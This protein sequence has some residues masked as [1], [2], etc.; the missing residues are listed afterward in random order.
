MNK[1]K[2]NGHGHLLPEPK[3]IP[4]FMREKKLFWIDDDKGFMR[5]GT[6]ARPITDPSFFLEEKL[7]WMERNKIEHEVVLNLSQLYCNGWS[8][9]DAADGI[10]FQNDFNAQVQAEN[11]NKFTCGFVVQPRYTDQ[12]LKEIERCVTQLDMKLLC[13]P[14]H[15]LNAAGQWCSSAHED[16][17]PIYELANKY[18]LA[19]EIHPYDGPK[20]INLEDRFW[21]FHLVWMCAQ[22]ADTYHLY[23][24]LGIAQKYP[25]IRTCF[26]HAN[27]YGQANYGRR[28]QGYDGRPDLFKGALDPRASLGHPNIFFDTLAHDPYT[29]ELVKKR[30][31]VSQLLA[32]LDDP[33][34]LGEMETVEGCYPGKVIDEA[35]EMGI[36]TAIEKEQIWHDNVLTWL[37]IK[38][39]N[40]GL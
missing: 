7:A 19:I 27:Q 29:L 36:F 25:N 16:V 13:L 4:A 8:E 40:I 39:E 1:A 33:Y 6:W 23:T 11:P 18:S 38:S 5:Q 14:T 31:G 32:G 9:E 15:Y 2:I 3:Q 12:A 24:L 17:D 28:L 35:L 21:R 10:R 30:S 22:T 34:P 26:A 20:M 37:G